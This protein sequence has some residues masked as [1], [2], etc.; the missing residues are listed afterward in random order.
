MTSDLIKQ[1]FELREENRKLKSELK[2]VSNALSHANNYVRQLENKIEKMQEDEEKRIEALVNKAVRK[3]VEE[4]NKEHA[5][6]IDKL[7]SKINHLEARLNINS[8]NSNIPTSKQSIGKNII[9]NNRE[10]SNNPKGGQKGHEIHKLEY[11]KEDE[12]TKTIVHTMDKCP[13][14][15]GTLREANVVL[16]DIIDINVNITKTRHQ[17]HNYKC[18]CCHKNI[19]SNDKLP[20]GVTYG[21][22]INSIALSLMNEANTPLNKVTSFFKGVTKDEITLSEGYLAKLQK[23]ASKK[24]ETF[25]QD[26]TNQII[27]LPRLFWDD[28]VCKFGI[29][30]PSEGFNEEDKDILE[31]TDENNQK[32]K[33]GVIRFYGD[34]NW[35]LLIGHK[36]KKEEGV[37]QDGILTVLPRTCVVMHDHLLLNYNP[38]F[39]FINAECNE[40]TKRYLKRNMEILPSHTWANKMRELL[41]QTNVD[42]QKI[43]ANEPETSRF[44]EEKLKEISDS[45]DSIIQLAYSEND[46]CTLNH[47]QDKLDELKLIKRLE[48]F[49]VNHLLFAYDFTVAFTNNTSERGLRQVKRKL[50]VS[51]SFKNINRMKDYAMILSYIETCYRNGITRYQSLQRLLDDNPY[52]VEEIKNIITAESEKK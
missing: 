27:S 17:I 4:L 11:F 51:F 43:I 8:S 42:K 20:R 49:K 21:T 41:I 15:G 25:Y 50:A 22:N 40:H 35:A 14:C 6:E 32:Y 1:N 33:N 13:E 45:Y 19:T 5:K 52:T 12:I 2:R 30:T 23:K 24:L 18:N 46:S 16:S 26:L 48:K 47:I 38:D 7:Q 31:M 3:T 10:K 44:T 9:Q 29:E 37:K 36:N 28:T 34:D 39:N